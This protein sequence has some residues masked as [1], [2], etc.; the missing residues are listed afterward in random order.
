MQIISSCC[1]YC[2]LFSILNI[3]NKTTRAQCTYIYS[4]LTPSSL[5]FLFTA[6]SPT[7][8]K[9]WMS[10]WA[11]PLL[12][13]C[14]KMLHIPNTEV[15]QIVLY[16]RVHMKHLL[17]ECTYSSSFCWVGRLWSPPAL[18]LQWGTSPQVERPNIHHLRLHHQGALLVFRHCPQCVGLLRYC[19]APLMHSVSDWL[20]EQ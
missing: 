14:C 1:G 19:S 4:V 8:L 13:V 6:S 3:T 16:L 10:G 7:I 5:S 20:Q 11:M 17:Y 9:G 12:G 15:Y 18:L 2:Q